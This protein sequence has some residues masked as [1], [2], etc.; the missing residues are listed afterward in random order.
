MTS[1]GTA[2]CTAG[3]LTARLAA[4][5]RGGAAR[6]TAT[7]LAVVEDHRARGHRIVFTNG[8]FD[9]LHRGHVAYLRQAR[10]LGDLLVV[11][12]NSDDS[13]ARLKGPSAR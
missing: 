7:S 1:D 8:C 10:A 5:D 4:A 13:V 12:L 3:A 11:A 2:V 6:A 9:V